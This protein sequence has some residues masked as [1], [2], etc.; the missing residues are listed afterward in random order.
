[1]LRDFMTARN[2][3]REYNAAR[4]CSGTLLPESTMLCEYTPSA[5]DGLL[6]IIALPTQGNP[7]F[8]QFLHQYRIP[9][10]MDFALV[11][12]KGGLWDL[13][14]Q[15]ILKNHCYCKEMM[16]DLGKI[17]QRSEAEVE[18]AAAAASDAS[19]REPGRRRL[20]FPRVG[21]ARWGG[22]GHPL[23]AALTR[24]GA[25]LLPPPDASAPSPLSPPP[26]FG[27]RSRRCRAVD[28]GDFAGGI[29]GTSLPLASVSRQ[30]VQTT[31][32][33]QDVHS[34][35]N[36]CCL[37][38]NETDTGG[39]LSSKM[40][41]DAYTTAVEQLADLRL[42]KN[43]TRRTELS[44]NNSKEGVFHSW[45]YTHDQSNTTVNRNFCKPLVETLSSSNGHSL[46]FLT[47]NPTLVGAHMNSYHT[48]AYR[49]PQQMPLGIYWTNGDGDFFKAR[50][51][52]TA[53]ESCPATESS[54]DGTLCVSKWNMK[55]RN[56][57]V[58]HSLLTEESD[59][60]ESEKVNDVLLSYF[61]NMDLNL[62]PE[63]IENIE[64]A[65]SKH[66]N[67]VFPYPDFLPPPF[68][69]L[70]LQK[71]A[72]SKWD[73]WKIVFNPPPESSVVKLI[74]RLL[75]IER[76]QHLTILKEKTKDLAVSPSMV[77]GNR[78]S[79]TKSMHQLKQSKLS[80][81]SC[82]Q[83]AFNGEYEEKNKSIHSG[84]CTH[85][86]NSSKCTWEYCHNCKWSAGTS[87]I[88]SS[89]TKHL[90]ASCDAFKISKTPIILNSNNILLRRSSSCCVAAP[91]TQ[92]TVKMTS[93]KLLPPST[94][95][96]SPFTEKDSSKYKQPRTKKKLYRKNV[97]M[98]KTFPCQKLKSVSAMPKQKYTHIDKQ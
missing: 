54:S 49:G 71:L 60:S 6:H 77:L 38:G 21:G 81:S 86:W 72:L 40:Q 23:P 94:A 56:S 27:R 69:N 2:A 75:E 80:D 47:V 41:K 20:P 95:I 29:Y 70:D 89:S 26:R 42:S 12:K 48:V 28:R 85:E 58:D 13:C 45:R 92:S 37:L 57:N 15:N 46:N 88:R 74:S 59:V 52:I 8:M 61:K 5:Q 1:M 19:G 76:M 35:E 67:E 78:P 10:L 90:R 3:T 25:Q 44:Q 64:K 93:L 98:S 84:C 39:V 14:G 68:N 22:P 7:N 83:T 43:R 36:K 34:P 24:P 63:T 87:S 53:S 82:L 97:V 9:R 62:R 66:Q 4:S 30:N 17:L 65:S 79:S 50:N 31:D 91:R 51:E 18:A 33:E 11:W 55:L 32:L 73:D 16:E 96:T